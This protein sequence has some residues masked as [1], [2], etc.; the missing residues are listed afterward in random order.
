[1]TPCPMCKTKTLYYFDNLGSL[2]HYCVCGYSSCLTEVQKNGH[3]VP[4]RKYAS[5]RFSVFKDSLPHNLLQIMCGGNKS[6]ATLSSIHR[7]YVVST[8]VVMEIREVALSIMYLL[9]GSLI[10]YVSVVDRK[11]EVSYWKITPKGKEF[12]QNIV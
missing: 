12:I 7:A 8:G 9:S 4:V 2:W 6:P 5:S 11:G 3:T 1:M 10:D